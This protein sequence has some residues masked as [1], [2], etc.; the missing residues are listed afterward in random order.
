MSTHTHTH[1]DT[2]SDTDDHTH[3]SDSVSLRSNVALFCAD[4]SYLP[5]I[6]VN[7][8]QNS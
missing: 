7:K 8:H 5:V 2:T 6:H 1:T 4:L 3:K